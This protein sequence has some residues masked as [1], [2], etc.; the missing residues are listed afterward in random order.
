MWYRVILVRATSSEHGCASMIG[1]WHISFLDGVIKWKHFLR[2]WPFVWG[3][4]RWPVNSL[5]KGQWRRTLMFSLICAWINGWVNNREAG[6][7]RRHR[8]HYDV[9]VMFIGSFLAGSMTH[10]DVMARFLHY[11]HSVRGIHSSPVNY[12][13]KRL[14][15][16]IG[17]PNKL[18][19]KQSLCSCHCN[20]VN[21]VTRII[22]CPRL[23]N[24]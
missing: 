8:A 9:I 22:H 21:C 18:L 10:D 11:W 13:H 3:I 24:R 1:N 4:H 16:F 5:H 19:N 17:T 12:P 6:D 20:V 23:D 2:Y 15:C 7:L 14:Q